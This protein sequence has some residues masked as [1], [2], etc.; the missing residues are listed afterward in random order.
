MPDSQI[1]LNG[2]ASSLGVPS[3]YDYCSVTERLVELAETF[4]ADAQRQVRPSGVEPGRVS[5][6][7]FEG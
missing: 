1:L 3:S 2:L 4:I 6:F 7:E 5:M